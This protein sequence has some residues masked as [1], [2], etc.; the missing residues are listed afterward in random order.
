[1]LPSPPSAP[2]NLKNSEIFHPYPQLASETLIKELTQKPQLRKRKHPI[3]LA[4]LFIVYLHEPKGTEQVSLVPLSSLCSY[5]CP[6]LI[7]ARTISCARSTP[8]P[9]FPR[10][11]QT[12]HELLL[13]HSKWTKPLSLSL[14]VLVLPSPVI[15]AKTS[16]RTVISV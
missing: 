3:A 12:Q 9:D 7:T 16:P 8:L 14:L 2:G 1:M 6:N 4:P 13:S 15:D 11:N 5:S 10:P